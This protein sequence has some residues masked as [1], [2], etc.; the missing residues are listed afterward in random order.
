MPDLRLRQL[1]QRIEHFGLVRPA[2]ACQ[3]PF[4]DL[5]LPTFVPFLPFILIFHKPHHPR[6]CWSVND[7]AAQD[8]EFWVEQGKVVHVGKSRRETE[9]LIHVGNFYLS[10]P[11][12]VLQL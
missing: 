1:D 6:V 4:Q 11:K 12:I 3:M 5:K 9:R 8:G 7:G 10:E 2:V